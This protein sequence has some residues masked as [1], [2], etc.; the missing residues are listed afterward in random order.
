MFFLV[1]SVFD[2]SFTSAAQEDVPV[3]SPREKNL[4]EQCSEKDS[5]TQDEPDDKEMTSEVSKSI[6]FGNLHNP[7]YFIEKIKTKGIHVPLNLKQTER[8]TVSK[9]LPLQLDLATTYDNTFQ[10]CLLPA[11]T[12]K[13]ESNVHQLPQYTSPMQMPLSQCDKPSSAQCKIAPKLP[14][15][16]KNR[17]ASLPSH[18]GST[19]FEGSWSEIDDILQKTEV[20]ISDMLQTNQTHKK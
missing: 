6:P 10:G 2:D 15:K 8:N 20:A 5:P 13:S 16:P 9:T 19:K 14:L 11:F 1:A 12:Y 3:H 4:L 7:P 18:L 17:K